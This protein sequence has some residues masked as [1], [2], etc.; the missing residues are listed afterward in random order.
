M[1]DARQIAPARYLRTLRHLRPWQVGG[2][3]LATVR[4]RTPWERLPPAPTGLGG[5]YRPA[6][7]PPVHD[8]WN[9]RRELLA[10]RFQFLN[11]AE[12]PGWTPAWDAE[13]LPLLWRFHLHYF[14]YLHL[15]WP[16][17]QTELCSSWIA[18]NRGTHGVGWHP[19]PTSLR[20]VHWCRANLQAPDLQESLYRQ[21]AHLFRNV[22]TYVY[23]NHLLE[24]ARALIHA[25]HFFGGQGEANRWLERGLAIYR[26]E[27]SEQVLADG[28]HFERS[29]MYHALMLEGYLDVLNLLPDGHADRNWLLDAASRMLN[30]LCSTTHPDGQL[31][32]LNDATQEIALAPVSLVDYARAVAGVEGS[33]SS[34]FPETGYYV[35]RKE[36]L[37]LIIDAGPAGPDYLMAHAHADVFS[38]ELSIG[39]KQ[40][41]TDSGVFEYAPGPMRAYVRSTEAH[42]TIT[43][44]GVDQVECWGSFRVARRSAP[45]DVFFEDGP[46]GA[47]F[48]GLFRG[49]E[50]LI[51]D[52]IAH[53]RS[54]SVDPAERELRVED[55]VRGRGEHRIES[56]LNFHP[57]VQIRH[58]DEIEILRD[59][60]RCTLD[61]GDEPVAWEEGWYC[62]AFGVR[63]RRAVAVIGGRDTLPTTLAYSLRY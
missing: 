63:R 1:H 52:G 57:D 50:T 9:S 16:D 15:L 45:E 11:R 2:R 8:P 39:G 17:E 58:G 3:I 21:A 42:N 19:Y 44:D 33:L 47:R 22:E 56:R 59:G 43:I 13:D 61:V 27:T 49:Y 28:G 4:R 55:D 7:P 12:R 29:P 41:I 26:S 6:A 62:P 37:Y 5:A 54:L 36:Q 40:L 20:I 31:A 10:G 60:V 32:L 30:F 14:Q 48:H 23:G 46:S 18:G 38:F 51:G 34:S 53:R 24:N 25:G 35:V